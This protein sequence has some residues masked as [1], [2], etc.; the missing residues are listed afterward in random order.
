MFR[1]ALVRPPGPNFAD[2]LTTAGLG[3][4]DHDRAL[5]QHAAYCEALE[6]CGL[7]VTRL[8]PDLRHP[9]STFVE[10]T[11]VLTP[12]RVVLTR[13]GAPSRRGEVA[14]MREHLARHFAEVRSIEDPGTLDGGDICE[15]DGHFLIG[16]SRRT[17]EAGARGLAALLAEEGRTSAFIDIRDIQGILH[18]KSGIAYLGDGR[19]AA[20]ESLASHPALR[21]YEIVAVNPAEAYAANCVR[22][23]DRILVAAG[24]PR[25][26]SELRRLGYHVIA[27]EMAE[28]EKMDG[29]LSCLSLRF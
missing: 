27:L 6:G 19:V 29:G 18:L 20:I 1:H 8:D 7:R 26:E 4:P 11:A 24:H 3:R 23:N 22:V 13:P 2:G 17:N 9:D 10:D 21:G 12:T 28:F 5:A 14:S 16:I 15:A 25:F